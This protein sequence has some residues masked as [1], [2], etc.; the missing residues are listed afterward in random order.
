MFSKKIVNEQILIPFGQILYA[1]YKENECE[2]I[3]SDLSV[4]G[5]SKNHY[6]N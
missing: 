2:E 5:H 4:W 3:S 1:F 6:E